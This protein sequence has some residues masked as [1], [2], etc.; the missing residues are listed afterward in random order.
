MA[1]APIRDVIYVPPASGGWPR[2]VTDVRGN[3]Y[4]ALNYYSVV[5]LRTGITMNRPAGLSAFEGVVTLVG[6]VAE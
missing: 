6:G 1:D 3:V 4:L 5:E 2:L